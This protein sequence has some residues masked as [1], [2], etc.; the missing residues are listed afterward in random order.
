ME[1]PITI[2]LGVNGL[3]AVK[4]IGRRDAAIFADSNLQCIMDPADLAKGSLDQIPVLADV[5]HGKIIGHRQTEGTLV[6]KIR[7]GC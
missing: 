3:Q 2:D 5:L 4:L 7:P 6:R 1:S